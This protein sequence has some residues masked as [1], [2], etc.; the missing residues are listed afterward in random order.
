MMLR[1]EILRM[2]EMGNGPDKLNNLKD[3]QLAKVR[4]RKAISKAPEEKQDE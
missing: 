3:Y 4:N 2:P 1:A